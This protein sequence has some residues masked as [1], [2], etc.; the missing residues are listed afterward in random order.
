MKPFRYIWPSLLGVSLALVTASC[1]HQFPEEDESGEVV[2]TVV[3]DTDWL[4]DFVMTLTRAGGGDVNIRYDFRVY[5]KGNTT[6]LIKEFTIVKDDLTRQNYT[7]TLELRP[8]DYDLW[9]WSDYCDAKT[10]EA[11]YYDDTTFSAITYSKPY[12]GDT[13]LRDAFRGMTSFTVE[14]DGY[15][16]IQPI[17]A[18]I[19][20]S[21]PLARYKF[22]ATDFADFVDKESTRGKLI[23][24]PSGAPQRLTNLSDYTVKVTYPLYMP[25]VFNNFQNNPIDS[26]TGVTFNA[27]MQQ[28][29]ADEAQIAMDYTMV[30]GLESGVQVAIEIYDPDGV[31]IARTSTITVPTKRDRTTI[32]YGKFLTT[33]RT[34]GVGIDPD[35]EG[36]FNIEIK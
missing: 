28:I 30:N 22:V 24:D 15:Y 33:L 16:E 13:D 20:L 19:T 23:N 8:G 11:L 12:E 36:E 21:R 25:A 29:S 4:P 35:F 26:W 18:T 5:P 10:G 32:I 27:Q 14:A 2:L 31:L 6:D 34:D 9:C 3:Q 1:V 7:T 17:E